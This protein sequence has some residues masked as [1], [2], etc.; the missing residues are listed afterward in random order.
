[1]A[2]SREQL[3][4][5]V[6]NALNSYIDTNGKRIHSSY[7]DDVHVSSKLEAIAQNLRAEVNEAG[8]A[9]II[10]S[11]LIGALIEGQAIKGDKSSLGGFEAFLK[12]ALES[13]SRT[14][15]DYIKLLI[16]IDSHISNRTGISRYFDDIET[17]GDKK[18]N[19]AF[20]ESIKPFDCKK[21]TNFLKVLEKHG[22]IFEE[23]EKVYVRSILF[24]KTEDEFS[25][26]INILIKKIENQEKK[27]SWFFSDHSRSSLLN[28]VFESYRNDQISKDLEDLKIE[29]D[30]EQNQKSPES[31]YSLEDPYLKGYV[32][33]IVNAAIKRYE[34]VS[35]ILINKKSAVAQEAIL[36]LKAF[37]KCC[38]NEQV[39]YLKNLE[40]RY[41]KIDVNLVKKVSDE[42]FS[43]K[44]KISQFKDDKVKSVTSIDSLESLSE[45]ILS[46]KENDDDYQDT[47]RKLLTNIS[48]QFTHKD[49]V[50]S[51]NSDRKE[52]AERVKQGLTYKNSENKETTY[53]QLL[54]ITQA[55]TLQAVSRYP[56]EVITKFILL[57]GDAEQKQQL[58][59]HLDSITSKDNTLIKVDYDGKSFLVKASSD[60]S[61]KDHLI[62]LE[63]E[64]TKLMIGLLQDLS[65]LY[66]REISIQ[67]ENAS[68]TGRTTSDTLRF[69]GLM[70]EFRSER[71]KIVKKFSENPKF[72]DQEKLIFKTEIL[73][74]R[75]KD[76]QEEIIDKIG[77]D[78]KFLLKVIGNYEKF[79]NSLS[80]TPI[81]ES[82]INIFI[83]LLNGVIDYKNKGSVPREILTFID[84][85]WELI[86]KDFITR[87]DIYAH[88]KNLEDLIQNSNPGINADFKS[89][90]STSYDKLIR[91]QLEFYIPQ[92]G[93]QSS[94]TEIES[95]ISNIEQLK[96]GVEI[97]LPVERFGQAL[98]W[99]IDKEM[100]SLDGELDDNQLISSIEN[101]ESRIVAI[102][103]SLFDSEIE[104]SKE[105]LEEIQEVKQ[106]VI[107]CKEDLIAS[108]E[109]NEIEIPLASLSD[110]VKYKNL[111][112][113]LDKFETQLNVYKV[114][115]AGKNLERSKVLNAL[116]GEIK[117]LKKNGYQESD[118]IRL[119]ALISLNMEAIKKEPQYYYTGRSP[120]NNSRLYDLLSEIDLV[121][122]AKIDSNELHRRLIK[123]ELNA[124]IKSDFSQPMDISLFKKMI[125]LSDSFEKEDKNQFLKTLN[126]KLDTVY[127]QLS[128][129][130]EISMNPTNLWYCFN[131][132]ASLDSHHEVISKFKDLLIG[133]N[134]KIIDAFNEESLKDLN[135][136]S[137]L[138][139]LE[140]VAKANDEGKLDLFL[141][142]NSFQTE[143]DNAL[144]R[145][146]RNYLEAYFLGKT[147]EVSDREFIEKFN[148]F[149]GLSSEMVVIE[150]EEE[151]ISLALWNSLSDKDE[152]ESYKKY[153]FESLA[154]SIDDKK[155]LKGRVSQLNFALLNLNKILLN[156]KS[157]SVDH[158]F[159]NN[160]VS[161]LDKNLSNDQLYRV[162]KSDPSLVH[163]LKRTIELEQD[164]SRTVLYIKPEDS[165]LAV[166]VNKIIAELSLIKN[167]EKAIDNFSKNWVFAAS[168][169]ESY[170]NLHDK[171]KENVT[172][173]EVFNQ[174]KDMIAVALVS[175]REKNPYDQSILPTLVAN[176]EALK[177]DLNSY[178][179]KI[180]K[181]STNFNLL[182]ETFVQDVTAY[183]M[184]YHSQVFK[185]NDL[186]FQIFLKEAREQLVI[187]ES[188]F[189]E[190]LDDNPVFEATDGFRDN[191]SIDHDKAD[192]EDILYSALE[193]L[194]KDFRQAMQPMYRDKES[195]SSQYYKTTADK[196]KIGKVEDLN[197][198]IN[199]CF[200]E[201]QNG[202]KNVFSD[203]LIKLDECKN[204]YLNSDFSKAVDETLAEIKK[205]IRSYMT[206]GLSKDDEYS[207]IPVAHKV[208]TRQSVESKLFDDD[209]RL[210]NASDDSDFED[211]SSVLEGEYDDIE[212]VSI[213]VAI[214]QADAIQN[215]Q[216]PSPSISY[217]SASLASLDITVNKH[218]GP[219]SPTASIEKT[220]MGIRMRSTGGQFAQ[221]VMARIGAALCLGS[222]LHKLVGAV[223]VYCSSAMLPFIG[224]ALRLA[225]TAA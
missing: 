214:V 8:S 195:R 128:S 30:E 127:Q 179:K 167:A 40:K 200:A 69:I 126:E 160:V 139:S 7:F 115:L 105:D 74:A 212:R 130:Q 87:E 59:N 210:S 187:E 91:A 138:V 9:E 55:E 165:A 111:I 112:E 76:Y 63:P 88:Q 188:K 198:F 96:A 70:N 169:V 26:N 141:K 17:Y 129:G 18:H 106:Q 184:D 56:L 94:L 118:V 119:Q 199:N 213:G 51:V 143:A 174:C 221:R 72:T 190:L 158:V 159:L 152:I 168:K 109:Q 79:L 68:R 102:E 19:Q 60:F 54:L 64:K 48:I 172:K 220:S 153:F 161:L 62:K 53:S 175:L 125:K 75:P 20:L 31:T 171:S 45:E 225:R 24:S 110:E 216:P 193:K 137:A 185:D 15:D 27:Q 156:G 61:W 47:V 114:E 157:D 166:I 219:G 4:K 49:T 11:L 95:L 205:A 186:A 50:D 35:T 44:D 67:R 82:V 42:I 97:E 132:L 206:V 144:E 58:K 181:P 148:V 218:Q 150:E 155:P 177:E 217:G 135:H 162:L 170:K 145:V 43:I 113:A 21:I 52:A 183:A 108:K 191:Q 3:K 164:S 1:M 66:V 85:T 36:Y 98:A 173:A 154:D 116:I 147:N 100:S 142:P 151:N 124:F 78:K 107:R 133:L 189:K 209:I 197:N 13:I 34:N 37:E 10:V 28:N 222:L 122:A 201:L 120:K 12:N 99:A 46:L 149:N 2:D 140:K 192:S 180:N 33:T 176:L 92:L 131:L 211:D 208:D 202:N 23:T 194:K 203:L 77:L 25:L 146:K 65:V 84:A 73:G 71:E 163:I 223:L 5:I 90:L 178:L 80:D 224:D 57:N 39:E 121:S 204:S 38:T 123:Y 101:I 22:F 32:Q 29:V 103:Q 6:L 89:K 93:Q 83:N 196:D 215:T 117:S 104:F 136:L 16:G 182:L 134:N 207:I 86:K 41:K 81:R 14:N